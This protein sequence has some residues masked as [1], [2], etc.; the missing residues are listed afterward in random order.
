MSYGHNYFYWRKELHYA[1]LF[2]TLNMVV[3]SIENFLEALEK[4]FHSKNGVVRIFRPHFS[5]L[6]FQNPNF[7]YFSCHRIWWKCRTFPIFSLT[8]STSLSGPFQCLERGCRIH[9]K[10][11]GGSW[12]QSFTPKIRSRPACLNLI[13]NSDFSKSKIFYFSFHRIWL[14]CRAFIILLLTH[15]L[16][17]K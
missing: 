17:L 9:R 1:D 16:D 2:N 7:F 11:S 3:K 10:F 12:G 13:F 8:W 14:G 4:K 15:T 5:A 6:I